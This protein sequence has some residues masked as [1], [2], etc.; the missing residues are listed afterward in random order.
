MTQGVG[1]NKV[2]P[3]LKTSMWRNVKDW[4]RIK[5]QN[6]SWYFNSHFCRIKISSRA[7]GSWL[8]S[9]APKFT[10][11]SDSFQM[12]KWAALIACSFML[13]A[14]QRHHFPPCLPCVRGWA[15]SR[16]PLCWG[17]LASLQSFYH[18]SHLKAISG[19]LTHWDSLFPT[20]ALPSCHWIF[21]RSLGQLRQ[22]WHK[23]GFPQFW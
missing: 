11:A 5:S 1:K 20:A 15:S 19:L 8:G 21:Q 2:P 16:M 12:Q 23:K 6:V 14:K 3:I 17:F 13:S 7:L 4:Q 9:Q 18:W 22:V 10:A